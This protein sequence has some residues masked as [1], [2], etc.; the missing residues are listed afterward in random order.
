MQVVNLSPAGL[1]GDAE[2]GRAQ[3]GALTGSRNNAN[4]GTGAR[5]PAADHEHVPVAAGRRRR[6]T[7][8]ASTATTT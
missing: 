7:R 3:A 2:Q 4:Q 1:G 6:R 5:R 8:R